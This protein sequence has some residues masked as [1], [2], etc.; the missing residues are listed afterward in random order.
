MGGETLQLVVNGL[1]LGGMY[2]LMAA[3][4]TLVFGVMGVINF[5]HGEFIVAGGLL[6]YTITTLWQV[7]FWLTIVIIAAL[8]LVAGQLSYLITI[9][10]IMDSKPIVSLLLTFGLSYI[11]IGVMTIVGGGVY[12][13]LP[14]FSGAWTVA[15]LSLARSRGISAT[16]ALL[17]IAAMYGVLKWT[18]LGKTM[19]ATAQHAE[20]A[21]T[22]GID[23]ERSRRWAF[24]LGAS[25]AGVAG[26]L[27]ITILGLAPD[28]GQLLILKAF[29]IVV[30][31]G[32]GS[33]AGALIGGLILGLSEVMSAFYLSGGVADSIAFVLILAILI[34]RPQGL[35]GKAE[36]V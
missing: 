23:I 6:A 30:L 20:V 5:A 33:L 1:L 3:G 2:A 26:V 16:V 12:R 13:S 28:S 24:G 11:L 19:R 18:R 25:T 29:A 34:A 14:I 9:R 35:F 32:L 7:P 21:L 36:R 22:C 4:L 10:P 31:G 15:G 27:L 17:M 8:F